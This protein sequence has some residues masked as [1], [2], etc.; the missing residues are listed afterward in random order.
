MGA[1]LGGGSFDDINMTPL[2]DIVLVVLIIMMVNVPVTANKLGIKVPDPNPTEK[3]PPPDPNV[4]QLSVAVYQDGRIALNRKVLVPDFKPLLDDTTPQNTK[5]N[6]VFPLMQ[7]VSRRLRSA[8][9]K[10]VFIDAHPE[11]NYG[12]IVDMMDMAKE[13][14]A[15]NVGLARMKEDGPL[16]PTSIGDGVMPRGVALGSPSVVGYINEKKADDAIKPIKGRI[17]ACY[18]QALTEDPTLTGRILARVDLQYEGKIM[19][20][21]IDQN[22]M[23]SELLETCI[24][25]TLNGLT[26]PALDANDDDT[27]PDYERTARI[28]YPLLFSPG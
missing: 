2:I 14:G 24:N 6:L 20:A 8:K 17:R 7:E 4:E 12:V 15:L 26:F 13:A 1:K 28:V 5:D 22:S 10:N 9:K 21:V 18:E 16:A 3:P 27:T 19:E 23:E 25:E 11:V